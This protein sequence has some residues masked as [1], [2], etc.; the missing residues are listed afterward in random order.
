MIMT[1]QI[2]ASTSHWVL[3]LMVRQVCLPV[4]EGSLS[5]ED[6]NSEWPQGTKLEAVERS[7][8]SIFCREK[9]RCPE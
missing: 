3:D 9:L 4:F 8:G 7:N 1:L 5:E 2:I 6:I